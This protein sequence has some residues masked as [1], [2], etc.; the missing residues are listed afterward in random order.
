MR[1]Q[2][3]T[4]SIDFL[5]SLFSQGTQDIELRAIH[6]D[7]A[8]PPRAYFGRNPEKFKDYCRTH[9]VAGTSTYFGV[10]TRRT[11]LNKGSKDY[12]A[13][14]LAL[15]VDID[16]LK[17][18]IKGADAIQ[19][20]EFL[21]FPPSIIVNSG[22]GL[23]GYWIL[24]DAVDV[25]SAELYAPI[26]SALRQLALIL[27][28]DTNCCD[29]SRVMRLP[30]TMNSKDATRALN[31]GEPVLC[32]VLSSNGHVYDLEQLTEW[33][34][35]QRP[36]LHGNAPKAI[37]RAVQDNPF[38]AYAKEAGYNPA[39]DIEA[40]LAAME[41]GATG[42]RSI[43][44]T[45]IRV[46]YSMI[47][48]DYD[49][50]DI[51]NTILAAT[52]AAAPT[53]KPWDW[54]KEEAAIRRDIS[55][56]RPKQ[57][58]APR[59]VPANS[60]GRADD[61]NKVVQLKPK[62]QTKP[63]DLKREAG[64]DQ[65]T[66]L[67]R[68]AL[69]VWRDRYGPILLSR[70]TSYCYENGVW[71]AWD[72]Q[73]DQMLRILMQEACIGLK[74]APKGSLISGA[75]LY[76]LNQ[77]TMLE[78][79][80]EFDR[81]GLIIAGDGTINPAT[82]ELG[83]HSPDHRAAFKVGANLNGPK[84]CS[85][86]L[87]FL[88]ESFAD[89]DPEEL[90]QIIATLQE[91]FGACLVSAKSR[92]L[93][94]GLLVYGGSRTGKTQL[95]EILRALMGRNQTSATSA[96]DLGSDFG[97]QAFVGKRG[98]IAD[99]AIG[100][101]EYLDAERYKK[102]VTGEE[103]SVRRKN[104]SDLMCRFGF[105][106]MLTA[107]NLP[108]IKDQSQAVYNRSLVL[109]MTNERPESKPEPSGYSS[110]SAKVI[111]EELTGVLWWA[112]EGWQRLHAR[113]AF[114]EP[115]CMG[116]AVSEMQDRSNT[117]RKWISECVEFDGAYK[118]ASADLFASFM[119]WFY[120]ENGDASSKWSQNG[121]TRRIK[122]MYPKLGYQSGVKSRGFVG[123]RLNADG[124]EYWNINNNRE[125]KNAPKGASFDVHSVN[126]DY[127]ISQARMAEKTNSEISNMD[128]RPRF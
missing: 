11:G 64:I 39:L 45:Q 6:N 111:A 18:G 115:P 53:D 41:H 19:A 3:Y 16:C 106:V 59:M 108:R 77:P 42:D 9:D 17:E 113:G 31:D 99:D 63:G 50:D 112:I 33:V 121:L 122:E 95:S 117:A 124:L 109:P 118:V 102:I 105:P 62:T 44:S 46:T 67:G 82:A 52:V 4:S 83:A 40:E 51:V 86:F 71:A 23:H 1:G 89:K 34:A 20:L 103:I 100:Q 90:P 24:E 38:A 36:I 75:T 14:C 73:H 74:L 12:V 87:S 32:E 43:H 35:E 13:E 5:K 119:G 15:W 60:Q 127:N 8:A 91:W 61:D 55:R 107:N 69:N 49:D 80:V 72:E 81:H 116:R 57:A 98:W 85:A 78:R 21:P 123:I 25:S 68:A 97:L 27:A 65:I 120:L 114:I 54:R 96:G 128:R 92:A 84:E 126:Q 94:K 66:A 56:A 10:C 29:I 7:G 79:E 48:R 37:V 70:G 93:C 26:E 125:S 28:G 2:D 104:R 76:F 22:G 88:E 30:G 58:A 110:I 101:D 47:A